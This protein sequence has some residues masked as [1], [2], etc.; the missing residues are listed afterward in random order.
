MNSLNRSFV[1]IEGDLKP[2]LKKLKK[3]SI[4]KGR[5]VL[6]LSGNR[7]LFRIM[8][9][10]LIMESNVRFERS[11]E[12]FFKVLATR[13]RIELRIFDPKRELI[14]TRTQQRMDIVV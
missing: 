8:A 7:Y 13:P 10:N 11:E 4:I 3:G 12:V 5:I 2:L 1:I 6:P 9:R 14:F